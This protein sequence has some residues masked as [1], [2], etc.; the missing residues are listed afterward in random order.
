MSERSLTSGEINMLRTVYGNSI[1]YVSLPNSVWE[2][3][4]C[5]LHLLFVISIVDTI[6]PNQSQAVWRDGIYG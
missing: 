2:C 6:S 4:A 1:D 3:L 5:K